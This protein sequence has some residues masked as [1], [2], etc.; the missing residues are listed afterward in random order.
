MSSQSDSKMIHVLYLPKWYPNKYDS[1]P[2]LF[3][4]RHGIAVSKY[5]EVSVLYVHPD[6]QS[7]QKRAIFSK[8]YEDGLFTLR[9]YFRKSSISIKP[10]AK[11]INIIRFIFYN[12][13]GIRIIQQDRNKVNLIHVHVLTRLAFIAL[14]YKKFNGT[15]FLITEHWT[16]YLPNV[17]TFNGILRR[18]ISRWVVR[19]AEAVLPVTK[20]LQIAMESYGLMNSNYIVV[21]NVVDTK[22]F[23]PIKKKDKR[24]I[25]KIIHLSCFT[26]YHKNIS[27]ILRVMKKLSILRQDFTCHFVGHG[28]DF[29]EVKEL[30]NELK[31]T[32]KYVYFDGL[33]EGEELANEIS[34][35]DLM[36]LFS[37]QENLPVVMLESFASGVPVISTDVGGIN[38]HIDE[39]LGILVESENEDQLLS[40]IN[41]TLDNLIKFNT[42]E[43]R[44]YAVDHFSYEVVGKTLFE[45]YTAINSKQA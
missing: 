1:M 25:K 19:K 40:V 41:N 21:P 33:K 4:K 20:N 43:I 39:R 17:N 37:R 26:N 29:D 16:R 31:L 5:C 8:C 30:S 6:A 45:I 22:V 34:S 2:G 36:V 3:I 38:E 13:K 27:G 44:Q 35:A 7:S 32:S 18:M 23:I 12:F 10:I 15:P 28:E 9:I 11:S 42:Q 24:Q 14:L